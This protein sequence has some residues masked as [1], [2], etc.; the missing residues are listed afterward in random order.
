MSI[1]SR[2]SCMPV[3][4]DLVLELAEGLSAKRLRE[5]F[6]EQLGERRRG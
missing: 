6:A 3:L 5:G 1:E 2:S 4:I